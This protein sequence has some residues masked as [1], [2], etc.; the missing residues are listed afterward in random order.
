MTIFFSV[1]VPSP[2]AESY[3]EEEEPRRK[4]ILYEDLRLKNRENYEVT[5]TQ[6]AETLLKP[7]PEKGSE[8]PQKE[9]KVLQQI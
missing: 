6:R 8:R 5:L 2:S 9:G 3:M 4:P 1:F 7:S